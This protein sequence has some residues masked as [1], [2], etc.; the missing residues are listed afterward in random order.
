MNA[1]DLLAWGL[2]AHL[3]AD[4]VFQNEW[5][6]LGKV[7]LRHPAAY[8]HSGIHLVALACVFKWPVAVA[9]AITHLLIDTRVP[10][11]FWGRVIKQTVDG[12]IAM[13]IAI[14]R[15]QVAHIALVALA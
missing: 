13:H 5:Q 12:P 15:D 4:W 14:W 7:S 10:L 11:Q 9:L 6:A 2:V 8:V 3:V 1:T